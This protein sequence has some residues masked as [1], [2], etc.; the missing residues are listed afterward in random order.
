MPGIDASQSWLGMDPISYQVDLLR[1]LMLGRASVSGVALDFGV[2]LA[3]TAAL[4]LI[5]ARLYPRA[6]T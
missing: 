6:A 2:L 4:I 1:T 5:G 3:A